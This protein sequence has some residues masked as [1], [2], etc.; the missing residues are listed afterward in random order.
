MN[1]FPM[2]NCLTSKVLFCVQLEYQSREIDF[3]LFP[4]DNLALLS[5]GIH[6]SYV[7][8]AIRLMSVSLNYHMSVLF[9]LLQEYQSLCI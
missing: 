8:S 9:P 5:T 3:E 7:L 4:D 2:N 6:M 1:T